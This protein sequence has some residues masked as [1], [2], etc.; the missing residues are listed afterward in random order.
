MRDRMKFINHTGEMIEF[1]K[2]NILINENDFRD[3]E[4]S[5]EAQYNKIMGFTRSISKRTLPVIVCGT[6]CKQTVNR[7]LEIIEK[8]VLVGKP[9]KM[10][11]GDYYLKGFF[12]ASKQQGYTKQNSVELNLKF[13]SEQKMWISPK[14]FTYRLNDLL[15]TDRGL[16]YDYGYPYDF[17][18]SINSQNLYNSSHVES[19]FEMKIYGPVVDPAITLAGHTYK[20][21]TELYKNEYL[22]I[23]TLE[24]T[25]IRTTAKGVL[26][27]E[28]GNRDIESGYIFQ[29]I[30]VGQNSVSAFPECNFDVT[31][32]DERSEP[33][34]T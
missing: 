16:G 29:K 33:K 22:T 28:F 26:V 34:W 19:N 27:N 6:E 25:V 3:Y 18:S 15:V 9:G 2:G 17:L 14:V 24:K 23:N 5:Y 12:Y 20:I 4:W 10:I 31:V 11:I 1:G 7:I 8:D 13:V 21:N 30:P 32:F